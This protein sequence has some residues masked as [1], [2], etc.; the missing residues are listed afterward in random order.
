[1][2]ALGGSGNQL[3]IGALR[4][5]S[6]A[7]TLFF[8]IIFVNFKGLKTL[9]SLKLAELTRLLIRRDAG[10]QHPANRMEFVIYS[11]AIKYDLL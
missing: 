2:P 1:M 9:E 10:I 11:I 6:R 4:Q 8:F 3:A 5:E 7:M